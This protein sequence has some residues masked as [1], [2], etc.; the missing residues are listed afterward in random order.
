MYVSNSSAACAWRRHEECGGKFGQQLLW[1]GCERALS[2]ASSQENSN[3]RIST[4]TT[5]TFSVEPNGGIS[6][7]TPING[8]SNIIV[9]G[10]HSFLKHSF[11]IFYIYIYFFHNISIDKQTLVTDAGKLSVLDSLL[12]RLKEQGH[13]VLIYSQMTKMIDLLEVSL[14][15]F[16]KIIFTKFYTMFLLQEYMY[17]K[18]H[19]FMRLDGSSKISDRRDMVADFQKR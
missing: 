8:W 2:I 4:Q 18:K 12:R 9:P 7:C 5:S 11:Y 15:K 14:F 3:F 19:T 1:L 17:H 10:K 16:D 13:R 6:A